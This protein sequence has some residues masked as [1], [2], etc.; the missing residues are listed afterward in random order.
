MPTTS[1]ISA[2]LDGRAQNPRFIQKQL[3]RLH[4]ALQENADVLQAAAVADDHATEQEALLEFLLSLEAVRRRFL[5][6][7]QRAMLQDEYRVANGLDWQSRRIPVGIVV[8]RPQTASMLYSTVAPL[9]SAI[10]AG[11]CAMIE[12]SVDR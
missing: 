3:R 1:L 6:L 5:E 8:I 11:N 7:D 10:A 4:R 2:H 12:V 9:V